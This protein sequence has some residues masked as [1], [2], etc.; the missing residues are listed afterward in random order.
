MFRNTHKV[1]IDFLTHE[2]GFN[3]E[4]HICLSAPGI[5][6]VAKTALFEIL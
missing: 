5:E 4:G 1:K 2:T 3:K 6:G